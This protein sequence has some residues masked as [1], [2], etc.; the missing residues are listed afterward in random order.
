ME[1][2]ICT[3]NFGRQLTDSEK[4]IF[5]KH[6]SGVYATCDVTFEDVAKYVYKIKRDYNRAGPRVEYENCGVMH[7]AHRRYNLGDAG[8]LT[9]FVNDDVVARIPRDDVIFCLPVY[10]YDHGGITLSHSAFGCSF[11]SGLL[12]WHYV[13]EKTA[14]EYCPT[15]RDAGLRKKL[16][17]RLEAE[18][19]EYNAFLQGDVYGY[20]IET[21][22]GDT[23]YSCW[24]FIGDD[25][26]TNGMLDNADT[27]HH[28][29]LR[30]A[31]EKLHD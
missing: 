11:D 23:E 6:I 26:E 19:K 31:W 1:T 25:I 30:A 7:C 8:A 16:L 9:P 10:M 13:I 15:Y 5:G 29:G 17:K 3:V 12:G 21:I 27:E 22:D 28:D 2:T 4:L 14:R 20:V 18:L 24:G